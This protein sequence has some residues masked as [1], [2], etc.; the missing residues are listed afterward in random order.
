[1]AI[2]TW[3]WCA[4]LLGGAMSYG[5]LEWSV[6]DWTRDFFATS[7]ATSLGASEPNL[8]PITTAPTQDAAQRAVMKSVESLEGWEFVAL[9]DQMGDR[10]LRLTRT[11]PYLKIVDD[12]VVTI[13]N[14]E[15]AI[16]IAATSQSRSAFG[17]F[18]RNPRNIKEL[19]HAIRVSLWKD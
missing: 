8:Q 17:D 5:L 14:H 18:G 13:T 10:I 7:A 3:I 11:S 9:E 2:K 6:D 16:V 19:F 12:V 1:M 4:L 15:D